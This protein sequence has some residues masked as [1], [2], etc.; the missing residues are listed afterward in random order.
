MM[1]IAR[2]LVAYIAKCRYVA[3]G[4]SDKYIQE[5]TNTLSGR[6]SEPPSF[7]SLV[8][9]FKAHSAEATA[10]GFSP[11]GEFLATGSARSIKIWHMKGEAV[12]TI[13]KT[14]TGFRGSIRAMSFSPDGAILA[15]G[16]SYAVEV[17]LW[18][19]TGKTK[20]KKLRTL[21]GHTDYISDVMF[22]PDGTLLASGSWDDT[23]RVWPITGRTIGDSKT[24]DA[25]WKVK[26]I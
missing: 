8:K 13:F 22:S 11:T 20:G 5:V 3:R 18:S 23:C 17:G 19:L 15:A 14:L 26:V 1:F 9:S 2:K 4:K 6:H 24:L 12:G 7:G 16:S 21:R 25:S 10:V